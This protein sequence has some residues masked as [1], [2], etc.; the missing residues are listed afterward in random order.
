MD[1][2]PIHPLFTPSI[3]KREVNFYYLTQKGD[4][5]KLK[6]G[7][8]SMMQGQIL[9]KGKELGRGEGEGGEGKGE[10]RRERGRG[11]GWHFSSLIFSRFINFNYRNYFTL[12]KIVLCIFFFHHNFMK[13]VILSCLK[14]NLKI[15]HKHDL[16]VKGFKNSK[17]D[18]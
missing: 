1:P 4:S 17:I 11:R 18:F 7:A 8:G 2:Q 6:K 10:R 16:F 9:F 15:P 12:C 14:M 5:E 3:L 13:K